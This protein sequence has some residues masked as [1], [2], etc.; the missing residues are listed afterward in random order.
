VVGEVGDVRVVDEVAENVAELLPTRLPLGALV[1]RDER[2]RDQVVR[3]QRRL[4]RELVVVP[5]Q[6]DD[7][8]TP[9]RPVVEAGL[10]G[11]RLQRAERDVHQSG[12]EGLLEL[13][14]AAL[15][16]LDLH[17]GVAAP[18]RRQHFRQ[19]CSADSR[20]AS[21]REPPTRQLRCEADALDAVAQALE[22][23]AGVRE[24]GLS[25]GGQH[26]RTAGAV[27]Q[28]DVQGVLEGGDVGAHPRLRQV[29]HSRRDREA[30]RVGD[31]EEGLQP[32]Q[33][34]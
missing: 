12:G 23:R 9:Q 33:L 21:D 14:R 1:A 22:H 5:H 11:P 34:H 29:Q 30:T 25:R 4:A 13:A 10:Q 7:R 16:E 31:G 2:T 27:E 28:R 24:E 19:E 17:V 32:C 6:R 26:R 15:D 20:V 3:R 8:L 18:H